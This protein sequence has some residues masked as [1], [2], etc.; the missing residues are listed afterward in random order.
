MK[1]SFKLSLLSG[2]MLLSACTTMPNGPSVMALPGTGKNFDQFRVDDADCQNYALYQVG[3]TTANQASTDVGLRSAAIGTAV[4]AVAGATIGGHQGAGAGAGAGLIMG[5][6]A[7]AGAA[8]S[9]AYG[10][11]QR[12]DN[13]YVQCMYAKGH[14]VPVAAGYSGGVQQP[15]SAP[16]YQPP[17]PP[18]P[19]YPPPR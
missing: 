7:G 3:G 14:R 17:P 4:G 2:L 18:P 6:M 9:S 15:S 19:G 12:Y 11:Q 16:S 5:S 1:H 13:A 10:S 8:E